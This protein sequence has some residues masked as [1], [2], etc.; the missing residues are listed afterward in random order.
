MI[1]YALNNTNQHRDF[2]S[3]VDFSKNF[4]RSINEKPI[5]YVIGEQVVAP[6]IGSIAFVSK[7]VF[8]FMETGF[9][10]LKSGLLELYHFQVLPMAA[11]DAEGVC[12]MEQFQEIKQELALMKER[13]SQQEAKWKEKEAQE[14]LSKIIFGKEEWKEIIG[15]D[16]GEVPPLPN[17]IVEIL[18][19][20]CPFWEGKTIAETHLLVFMPKNIGEKP[21][22][23]G[24][25]PLLVKKSKGKSIFKY[26]DSFG[27]NLL[28][29]P[30]S[31]AYWFLMTREIIPSSLN[32]LYMDQIDLVKSVKNTK[33]LSYELPI[34]LE[35]VVGI[36]TH[37][38]KTEEVLPS[39]FGKHD[40]IQCRDNQ[41]ISSSYHIGSQARELT[42]NNRNPF[43]NHDMSRDLGT[44]A[45]SKLCPFPSIKSS[46]I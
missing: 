33:G 36:V 30:S 44:I 3:P 45:V 24:N 39:E 6:A 16:V 17:D 1:P 5:G 28:N 32:K 8:S 27:P 25:F 38:L 10:Y 14:Y 13:L 42:I 9:G 23:L 21:M 26:S 41:V 35:A 20:P 7:T 40:Y 31:E 12:D 29:R 18:K 43:I 46:K 2:I 22:T 15:C 4:N 37:Y 19:S 34:A 11:A